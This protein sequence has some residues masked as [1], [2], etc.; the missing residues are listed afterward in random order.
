MVGSYNPLS[1]ILQFL[2]QLTSFESYLSSHT[3]TVSIKLSS[4]EILSVAW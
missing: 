4:T 3:A 2:Y 1:I